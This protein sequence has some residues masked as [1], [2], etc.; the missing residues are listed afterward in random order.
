MTTE[1]S[2]RQPF[3]VTTYG[4]TVIR[5]DPDI[6]SIHCAVS[7]TENHPKDAFKAVREAS[8]QVADYL[9]Q[10]DAKIETS[11]SH[12]SLSQTWDY[13]GAKQKFVGYTARVGFH[14]LLYDLD[15]LESLLIGIVDSGANEI[16]GVNFQT[17]R[18]KELRSEARRKAVEAAR[19]KA[20]NYCLAAQVRLGKVLHIEDVNPD[21][22]NFF[23]RRFES[24]VM[25]QNV[26][27]QVEA[28]QAE[29][30][31]SFKPGSITINAAV[32]MSF[33]IVNE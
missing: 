24:H 10:I 18:L 4:S 5:I 31:Q 28:E 3:G 14:T 23:G 22:S 26:I 15:Q 12:I 20:E 25:N 33:S 7:R 29:D 9:Q 13:S 8:K 19:E 2:I 1:Q 21:T 6:A 17:S 11:S 30:L 16:G 32:L 27:D